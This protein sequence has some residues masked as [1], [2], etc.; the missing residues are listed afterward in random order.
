MQP[1]CPN[2]NDK[3]IKA[4]FDELVNVLGEDEAYLVWHKSDG[5][6]LGNH[7]GLADSDDFKKYLELYGAGMYRQIAIIKAAQDL[8]KPKEINKSEE[9]VDDAQIHQNDN[10]SM[11]SILESNDQ[12][13]LLKKATGDNA[14]LKVTAI[15]TAINNTREAFVQR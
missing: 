14:H 9:N 7:P 5:E 6:G 13:E 8:L 1:F 3:N 12:E 15:N 4:E 10:S 11:N 2:L